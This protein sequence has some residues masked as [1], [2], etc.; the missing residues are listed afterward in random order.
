MPR[1]FTLQ[2]QLRNAAMTTGLD[3]AG[4][5]N[6]IGGN[7][8]EN[9]WDHDPD[10]ILPTPPQRI[11][12]LNGNMVGAWVVEDTPPSKKDDNLPLKR[13]ARAGELG[14]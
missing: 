10:G 3:L 1:V 13:W 2:I 11:K 7:L 8:E 9:L 6:D 5:L 4:A 12:D 14:L